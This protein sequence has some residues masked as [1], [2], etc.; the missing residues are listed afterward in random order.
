MCA[1]VCVIYYCACVHTPQQRRLTESMTSA[2]LSS[3]TGTGE[4][5]EEGR[6]TEEEEERWKVSCALHVSTVVRTVKAQILRQRHEILHELS[7]LMILMWSTT[8]GYSIYH[9]AGYFRRCK[10]S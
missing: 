8:R 7:T 2:L 4:G 9:I 5:R 1:C 6:E 10:F 3:C